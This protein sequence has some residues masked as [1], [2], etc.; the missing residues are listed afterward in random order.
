[1]EV[2]IASPEETQK[3]S[4]LS[5]KQ[6]NIPFIS[7]QSIIAVLEDPQEKDEVKKVTGFAAVQTALHA[8]GSWIKEEHRHQKHSYELRR[9]LDKELRRRG[10]TVY[11]AFPA[12]PFEQHLFAKYGTVI[13]HLAQ[14]RHL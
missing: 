7:G 9:V 10:F 11:F 14:I 8:A 4:Q 6:G 3:L 2:R 5:V 12:N 13:E 1:M